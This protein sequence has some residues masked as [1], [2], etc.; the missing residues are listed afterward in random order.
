MLNRIKVLCLLTLSLAVSTASFAD[1]VTVRKNGTGNFLTIQ[2]ALESLDYNN[3]V[4]DLVLIGPGIYDQQLTPNADAGADSTPF[5]NIFNL[6]GIPIV[7]AAYASHTD[8]LTLR[9][10]DPNDPP[11]VTYIT[12][13]DRLGQLQLY[14]VFP[15]N[16][17]DFFEAA[18]VHCGNNVHWENIELR[19]GQS[20][21]CQNGQADN[22]VFT[23]C[24]FTVGHNAA[25][26]ND[27]MFNLNNN[28]NITSAVNA[29][30]AADCGY[31]YTN[32]IYDGESTDDGSLM[33][34]DGW[35]FHGFDSV[36]GGLQVNNF[37]GLGGLTVDGCIFRNWDSVIYIPR[38][39]GEKDRSID[40]FNMTNCFG[41]S[42]GQ[43]ARFQGAIRTGSA[44]GN[45]CKIVGGDDFIEISD[46]SQGLYQDM[47]VANNI[48]SGTGSRVIR[49]HA[50]ATSAIVQTC[51]WRI[52]N[53][54]FYGYNNAALPITGTLSG[55]STCNIVIANNIFH[56][57]GSATAVGVNYAGQATVTMSTNGFFNNTGGNTVGAVTNSGA[58]TGDPSYAGGVTALQI[59]ADTGLATPV[60][61]LNPTNAAYLNTGTQAA[62]DAVRTV[63]GDFDVDGTHT[64]LSGIDI[65]AQQ[66]LPISVLDWSV[67]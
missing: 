15:D 61:G 3:G 65:G 9:G 43:M 40:F 12:G 4:N 47:V 51:N 7:E 42:V 38:G 34:G 32:C 27:A 53:N 57:D 36:P 55:G 30:I 6:T 18:I 35:Y 10:E 2:A 17:S 5:P 8:T 28:I 58:V 66:N 48:V 31:T 49:L 1:T 46:R 64:T 29:N 22:W 16:P 50:Q 39:R 62:Y 52:V 33:D 14:G 13:A 45:V 41:D 24:L 67:Y 23:D 44:V 37:L 19:H 25:F 21:Y 63:A 11:V 54:T 26:G 60:Q 59:P 20:E 56:G